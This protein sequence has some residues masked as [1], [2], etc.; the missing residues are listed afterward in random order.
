[1]HCIVQGEVQGAAR[2]AATRTSDKHPYAGDEPVHQC[3][4]EIR[5]L[6]TDVLLPAGWRRHAEGMGMRVHMQPCSRVSY[7]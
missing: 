3:F 2:P 6:N 1:M 5:C 7:G 4:R